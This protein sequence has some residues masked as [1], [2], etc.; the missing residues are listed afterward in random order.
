MAGQDNFLS[1]SW[2]Q[3]CKISLENNGKMDCNYVCIKKC[4]L[5][6]QKENYVSKFPQGASITF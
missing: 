5:L 2:S 4:G 1:P 6:C 3:I